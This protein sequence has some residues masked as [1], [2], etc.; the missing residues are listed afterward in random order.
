MVGPAL[1]SPRVSIAPWPDPFRQRSH[2]IPELRVRQDIAKRVQTLNERGIPQLAT[3]AALR[4]GNPGGGRLAFGA[5]SRRFAALP[6]TMIHYQPRV[7]VLARPSFDEPA[8]L[9]VEW[10]GESTGGER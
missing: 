4:L 10:I 5:S 7:S 3:G 2:P 9:P 8:H 1:L 6:P